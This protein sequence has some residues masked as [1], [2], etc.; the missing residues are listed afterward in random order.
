MQYSKFVCLT[1]VIIL[2]T[3]ALRG[4]ADSVVFEFDDITVTEQELV[5]YLKERLLPTAYEDALSRPGAASQ[6]VGNIYIIRSAAAA[7][8]QQGLVSESTERWEA[9]DAADRYAL[10]QFLSFQAE[11][12]MASV[13]WDELARERYLL[14]LEKLGAGVEVSVSHILVKRGD[15][16][17]RELAAAVDEVERALTDG[18]AFSEVAL[19]LS[20]DPSAER[21]AGALGYISR[22]ET[23]P[24]FEAAAFSMKETGSLSPPIL[25][26]FGV[27]I[28]QFHDKREKTAPSFDSLR[29]T[30]IREIKDEETAKYRNLILEPLRS[31]AMPL[32]NALDEPALAAR[33]LELLKDE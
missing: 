14:D 19:R 18:E 13:E 12:R 31:P 24:A 3:H 2:A 28:L 17:F 10:E 30:L 25:T 8:R 11:Q 21:N 16:N 32:L 29:R 4:K 22:G 6:A 9:M 23:D 20:E 27:H 26:S 33:L 1:M 7:A 5:E 15:R